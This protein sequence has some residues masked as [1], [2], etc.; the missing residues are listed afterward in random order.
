MTLISCSTRIN[1]FPHINFETV[2]SLASLDLNVWRRVVW[3]PL[4]V[5]CLFCVSA[6]TTSICVQCSL[7][8]V[9]LLFVTSRGPFFYSASI[10]SLLVV[11][12]VAA[13]VIESMILHCV[14]WILVR[15]QFPKQ[16]RIYLRYYFN[17]FITINHCDKL[18]LGRGSND[19]KQQPRKNNWIP[20]RPLTH[21]LIS[22]VQFYLQSFLNR[23]KEWTFGDVGEWSKHEKR[24][25]WKNLKIGFIQSFD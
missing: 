25:Q 15:C 12:A 3:V 20:Y 8:P 7:Q 10:L 23:I 2:C 21:A 6:P 5:C 16:F 9:H 18:N 24:K 22:Y 17:S 4:Y 19:S 14:V 13:A 11:A 1:H